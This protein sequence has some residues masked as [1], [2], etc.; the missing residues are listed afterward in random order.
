MRGR[1]PSW[2][3]PGLQNPANRAI[4]MPMQK[5][6]AAASARC[7]WRWS[8]AM[9]NPS[10]PR[11]R[12]RARNGWAIAA[13]RHRNCAIGRREGKRSTRIRVLPDAWPNLRGARRVAAESRP[14][15]DPGRPDTGNSAG[16]DAR[17]RALPGS[18]GGPSRCSAGRDDIEWAA[19][20]DQ[21]PEP[22]A[23]LSGFRRAILRCPSGD[24]PIPLVAPDGSGAVARPPAA[25]S[26]D[27]A[28]T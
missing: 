28:W 9:G 15:D 23:A 25:R 22:G 8:W 11:R 1:R 2:R 16:T 4:R 3:P 20:F 13:E 7:A 12:C 14:S 19:R 27:R 21:G 10:M 26:E 17:L 24:L 5:A 18:P 6:Q